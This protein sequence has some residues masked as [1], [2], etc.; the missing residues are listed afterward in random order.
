MG[1]AAVVLPPLVVLSNLNS[2]RPGGIFLAV[3]GLYTHI[4]KQVVF[5]LL[6]RDFDK[7]F[8]RFCLVRVDC[9][10]LLFTVLSLLGPSFRAALLLL[11][12][13]L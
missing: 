8:I 11:T 2:N 4:D 5:G 12:V 3:V 7:R 1:G 10:F 6:R 13:A 9:H